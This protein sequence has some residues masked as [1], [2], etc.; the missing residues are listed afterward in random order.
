MTSRP[1][2]NL[3]FSKGIVG[4]LWGGA[5]ADWPQAVVPRNRVALKKHA[6]ARLATAFVN[7]DM[8]SP[9]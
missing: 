9:S 7:L 5:G 3:Y 4:S 2:F 6:S 1:F 8:L